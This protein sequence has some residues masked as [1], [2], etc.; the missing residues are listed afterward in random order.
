MIILRIDGKERFMHKQTACWLLTE[1]RTSL[2]ADRLQRVTQKFEKWMF[3]MCLLRVF[4]LGVLIVFLSMFSCWCYS[5][6]LFF[7]SSIIWINIEHELWICIP[8]YPKVLLGAHSEVR[9]WCTRMHAFAIS[10][11][12]LSNSHEWNRMCCTKGVQERKRSSIFQII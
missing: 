11:R 2:P 4:C 5:L 3:C 8:L 9:A 6:F 1:D 10:E 7:V 12:H